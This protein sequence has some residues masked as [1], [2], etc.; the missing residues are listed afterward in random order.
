MKG[1]NQWKTPE[2]V[3]ASPLRSY[4][5][6][7]SNWSGKQASMPFRPE[8][9]KD[10]PICCA[11]SVCLLRQD[12]YQIR[13]CQIEDRGPTGH[14]SRYFRRA[15]S[16]AGERSSETR[17]NYGTERPV[18]LRVSSHHAYLISTSTWSFSEYL[19][20]RDWEGPVNATAVIPAFQES[21]KVYQRFTF[22]IPSPCSGL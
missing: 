17:R 14:C 2:S 11:F 22:P 7:S 9:A 18:P 1:G 4:F 3:L 21:V 10:L 6:P 5:K 13:S 15:V 20:N 19:P 16:W 8:S 12:A